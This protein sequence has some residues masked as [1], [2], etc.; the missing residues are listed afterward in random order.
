MRRMLS[1]AV[2][3]WA[4]VV[5]GSAAAARPVWLEAEAFDDLGGWTSDWQWIDQMGSPYLLSVGLGTP[6]RDAV[7]NVTLPQAG[8]YRLWA[9]TKDWVP[10]HH[11]GQFQV[12]INGRP[13]PHVFGKSGQ[14][15]WQWEDGGTLELPAQVEL[16]L[17]DLTGY[18]GRCDV[19]VLCDDPAWT[20]P[21]D[22]AALA[23]LRMQNGAISPQIE[24]QEPSDVVVIGGGL[25]GCVAATAAARQGARTVLLQNRP[26]LGGNASV[27]ILVPPVGFWLYSKVDPFNPH[28]TGITEEFRGRGVQTT[29]DGKAYSGRLARLVGAEPNL[30]LHLNT[31]ATGVEMAAPGKIA[32]VLAI[33]VPTGRRLR[34]PGKL[35]IDCSGDSEVSVAAGAEHRHGREPQAMYG[36]SMA[37]ETADRQT[38]GNSIKYV[39]QPADQPQPFTAPAW[40]MKF[41][42][43]DDFTPGRHPQLGGDIQWQWMIELGGTRDTYR[44]GEEIRDDLLR[45]VFGM[46]DHVKNHC[47]K[48]ADA[49]KE[50]LAWV[51]YVTGKRE[52]R[53]LIGDYVLQQKDIMERTLFPD[54]IGYG[55]WGIDDHFPDGFFHRG[56]PAQHD[57]QAVEHSIPYRSIYSK[58]V[59]NLLMAGRNIS[60]SHVA[61][62]ATRVMLTSST[63][64]QA[65]GTAAALC[66][67]HETTPRGVFFNY[68]DDLQQQ[69]LKDDAHLVE[70]PNRDP[71]DLARTAKATASSVKQW[72]DGGTMDAAAVNDGYAFA[73]VGKPSSWS[74]DPRQPGPAWLELAWDR[75]QTFNM[76]HVT[77]LTAQLAAEKV[78]VLAAADGQWRPLAELTT[79]RFRKFL[80]PLESTTTDRLRI[81]LSG[82][83]LDNVALAEVRVY[84][85]PAGV[86]ESARR[87]MRNRS[88]PDAGPGLPWGD[89]LPGSG[90]DPR[91]LGGI[92]LDDTQAETVGSWTRSTFAGPFVLEG[93][94]HDG[95]SDKGQKQVRFTPRIE[96]PGR[97]EIRL[98]YVPNANRCAAT[99]VTIRWGHESRQVSV[100]QRKKPTIDGMFVSLG[101]YDFTPGDAP[102]IIISNAGTKGF[103]VV[104]AVQLIL[105]IA[106]R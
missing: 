35:F 40:A 75:P 23:A 91:R 2:V 37:P 100:D 52:N 5:A 43:C 59:E 65:A 22:A 94:L 21:A 93:Y 39:S 20:P 77:F 68:L 104:D 8:R 67:Q 88:L 32:A 58:N 10:E 85:E 50:R 83:R 80:V 90:K 76:V 30:A 60:A 103:V 79:G 31:H 81:E 13:Q 82:Q 106:D 48:Y 96:Q 69:L 28:E 12:V 102:K 49:A 42:S 66:V 64:G 18:Y 34:F 51:G 4:T 1:W 26:V 99:P 11:P 44:D 61:M 17:H 46:W 15:G 101:E 97:Y 41:P 36:E 25:A 16:R 14:A 7:K 27:E 87:L 72:P 47:G 98:A 33:Q 3:A 29:A 73:H 95:N 62:S 19:I 38:M 9:R 53:R 56:R 63:L 92:V 57:Y 84:A 6:V 86:L 71:R 55:G 54:R 78:R 105:R 24:A 70:L 45:L 74:P 89:Y